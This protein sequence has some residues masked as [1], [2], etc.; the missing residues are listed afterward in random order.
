[1]QSVHPE[2]TEDTMK[3]KEKKNAEI[4][5]VLCSE[6][7]RHIAIMYVTELNDIPIEDNYADISREEIRKAYKQYKRKTQMKRTK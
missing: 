7:W 3:R 5:W 6:D 4:D 2:K 1:M